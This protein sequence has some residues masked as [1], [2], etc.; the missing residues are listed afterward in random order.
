[1]NCR[2]IPLP[3]GAAEPLAAL[4]RACFPEEPWDAAALAPILAL[5]GGFGYLAWEGSSPTGFVLARDLAGEIE[6]LSLGVVPRWRR[7]GIG[8]ALLAAV[9]GEAGRRG[10]GSIVLEVAAGNRAA[11]RLY[12]AAGFIHAGRRPRYYRRLGGREDALILRLG[13]AGDPARA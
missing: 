13:V 5:A 11:R 9:A 12:A 1:M 2:V 4:H 6:I 10:S 3:P 8:A 7:R